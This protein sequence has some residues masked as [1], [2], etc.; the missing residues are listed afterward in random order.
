[1]SGVK[2]LEQLQLFDNIHS[3]SG[4]AELFPEVWNAMERLTLPDESERMAGLDQLIEINAHRFSPLVAYMLATF[5]IDPDINFRFKIVQALGDLLSHGVQTGLVAENV[6]SSLKYY[7]AQMRR[8]NIYALLQVADCQ[9]SSENSVATLFKGCSH[10]GNTLS[11]IFLDRKVA[12]SIRSQAI[13][14]SGVVG[15]LDTVPEL[16]RLAGRLEARMNGQRLMTFA[17]PDDDQ[18]KSLLPKIQAA[19]T[20]LSYP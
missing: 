11:D 16:G 18:E 17:P 15:F 9:P 6:M 7:L 3:S 4:V 19:L 1:M 8:R 14:F 13:Y 5:L 10:A 2:S 12:I 20:L